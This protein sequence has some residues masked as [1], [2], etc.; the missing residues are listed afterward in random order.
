MSC[1]VLLDTPLP[2]RPIVVR[3][4]VAI[5]ILVY[6]PDTREAASNGRDPPRP[7]PA[8]MRQD[9]CGIVGN[10]SLRGQSHG[11]TIR[12]LGIDTAKPVLHVVGAGVT[13][14]VVLRKRIARRELLP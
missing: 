5:S 13:G 11:Q 9:V 10:R 3:I 7:G 6:G 14:H 8:S 4:D 2:L 12:G 1:P